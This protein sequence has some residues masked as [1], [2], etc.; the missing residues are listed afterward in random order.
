MC[1]ALTF[2]CETKLLQCNSRVNNYFECLTGLLMTSSCRKFECRSQKKKLQ[3]YFIIMSVLLWQ[4]LTAD[5]ILITMES[6]SKLWI[7][8]YYSNVQ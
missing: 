5:G 1:E 7:D 8:C 2:V 3:F 6:E 4:T